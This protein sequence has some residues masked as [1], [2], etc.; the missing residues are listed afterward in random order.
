MKTIYLYDLLPGIEIDFGKYYESEQKVISPELIK[1]GFILKTLYK[2]YCWITED[3]DSFGPLS[4]SI[5][6]YRDGQTYR[7]WYG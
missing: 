5:I 3:G 2:R 1:L 4:R 7:I 6:A